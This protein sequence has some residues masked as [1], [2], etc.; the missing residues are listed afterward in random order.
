[1]GWLWRGVCSL[2][3]SRDLEIDV[4]FMPEQQFAGKVPVTSSLAML[5]R[6]EVLFRD[7]IANA[8]SPKGWGDEITQMARMQK[9]RVLYLRHDLRI[10][11]AAI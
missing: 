4:V 6:C 9:A 1:M 7:V 3:L 5:S 2:I 11:V 8:N 10:Q